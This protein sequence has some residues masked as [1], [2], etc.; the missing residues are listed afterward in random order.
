[1]SELNGQCHVCGAV[2]VALG[3]C[4][5]PECGTHNHR[6]RAEVERLRAA[7]AKSHEALEAHLALA[8][9]GIEVAAK[10]KEVSDD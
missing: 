3:E 2:Q 5:D 1:M 8:R 9:L 10:H 6:L 4:A 7:L